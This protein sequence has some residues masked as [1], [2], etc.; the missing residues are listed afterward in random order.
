MVQ[1]STPDDH[2]RT[3]LWSRIAPL[4][5]G[6]LGFLAA[7]AVI[8]VLRSD[9]T[10]AIAGAL[11]FAGMLFTPVVLI[12]TMVALIPARSWWRTALC[13]SVGYALLAV[14]LG[15]A[16]YMTIPA[17]YL[18]EDD[19]GRGSMQSFWEMHGE[20]LMYVEQYKES[21]PERYAFEKD[22]VAQDRLNYTQLWSKPAMAG[23]LVIIGLSFGLRRRAATGPH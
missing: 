3:H 17:R 7:V 14:M 9:H 4:I 10:Q 5:A 22:R 23:W 20:E 2:L 16:G 15:I 12:G 19:T 6:V 13:V 11:F 1:T 18:L 8:A 21:E